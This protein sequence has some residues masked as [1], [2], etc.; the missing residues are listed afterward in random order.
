M[1]LTDELGPPSGPRTVVVVVGGPIAAAGVRRLCDHVRALLERGD[2]QVVTCDL[3]GF[4]TPDLG[5]VDALARPQLT[6]RRVGGRIRVRTA[7]A[8]VLLLLILAG[9]ADVVPACVGLGA[10]VG[11]EPEAGEH[12]RVQEVVDV[13]DPPG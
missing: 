1:T 11:G 3:G 10:G 5:I 2:A 6:A 8:E 9:L 7:G 4:D 12:C 13:A